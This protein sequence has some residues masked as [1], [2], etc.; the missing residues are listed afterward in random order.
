[1][2]GNTYADEF[3]YVQ[4]LRGNILYATPSCLQEFSLAQ[5]ESDVHNDNSVL[6]FSAE[7]CEKLEDYDRLLLERQATLNFVA[8]V[9]VK[10][11]LKTYIMR[12]RLVRDP[13]TKQAVGIFVNLGHFTPGHFRKIYLNV[14]NKKL[15]QKIK[16]RVV[17]SK[18]QN[19]IVFCLLLGFFSRKD[20][21]KALSVFSSDCS[22][23]RVKNA[24]GALYDKFS[25]N[26][27]GSLLN[28]VL[29]ENVQIKVPETVIDEGIYL[30][31]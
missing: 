29:Q 24:I 31:E 19:E 25:C 15:S 23:D 28:N 6:G 8:I 1:M 22:E 5:L 20:I 11:E 13:Q 18:L 30:I 16:R 9:R 14:I 10:A 26:D 4:D 17:L 2:V 3:A 27:T 21:A 7:I 12:K